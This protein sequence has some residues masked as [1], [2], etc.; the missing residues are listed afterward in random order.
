MKDGKRFESKDNEWVDY[1]N[2]KVQNGDV[3]SLIVDGEHASFKVNDVDLGVAFTD[4]RF[5]SNRLYPCIF[6]IDVPD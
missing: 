5:L 6:I 4:N 1:T 2:G 3:I